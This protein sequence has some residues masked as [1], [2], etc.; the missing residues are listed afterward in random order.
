MRKEAGSCAWKGGAHKEFAQPAPI[1]FLLRSHNAGPAVNAYAPA[2]DNAERRERQL[3]HCQELAELGMELARAAAREALRALSA[4]AEH[5]MPGM[6]APP[7]CDTVEPGVLF[8]RVSRAVRQAILLENR[9][10]AGGFR[11]PQIAPAAG[12]P[13]PPQAG[14]RGPDHESVE[15]LD[16]DLAGDANRSVPEILSEIGGQLGLTAPVPGGPIGRREPGQPAGP[17]T[18]PGHRPGLRPSL[19]PGLRQERPAPGRPQPKPA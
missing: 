5:R 13:G 15:T 2:P 6:A 9:I 10:L 12:R 17:A 19:R 18:Q 8:T 16:D 1:V 7:V 4:P 3:R 11:P 14:R